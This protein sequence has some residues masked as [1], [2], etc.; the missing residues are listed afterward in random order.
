MDIDEIAERARED[1]PT[2]AE[3]LR[4]GKALVLEDGRFSI[5]DREDVPR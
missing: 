4:A 3:A 1:L 5:R 2:W